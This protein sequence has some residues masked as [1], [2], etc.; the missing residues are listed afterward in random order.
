M[1]ITITQ[2][3]TALGVNLQA[4]FTASGGTAPYTY[5]VKTNPIGA[6]GSINSTTGLYTAPPFV[7]GGKYALANQMYDTIQAK[8]SLGAIGT[9]QILVAN[10]LELFCDVIQT[11]MGLANGRVYLWNQKIMQPTDAGLYVAV[12]V[13][14]AKPFA[15][16]NTSDG[17][18]SGL[19]SQQSV[20][21]YAQL[22]LDV[23]SRDGE[24][25]DRKEEVILALNS[26]YSRSQQEANSFY[27][28]KLPPGAQFV[29]LSNEDGAAIPY[30][31]NISVAIQYC[32]VKTVAVP[33]FSTFSTP[34]VNNNP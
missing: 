32:Y 30:R 22:Q 13:M 21:M 18:G 31:F 6:G 29:N 19:N 27:I 11:S 24:A 1:S 2:S 7:N 3:K 33:Y 34:Q 20:N 10:P 8:D 23:I 4:G 17:S 26:D 12:A 25:R 14:S 16:I 9:T 15:S 5:S 28:G